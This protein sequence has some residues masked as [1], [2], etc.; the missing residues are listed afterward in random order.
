MIKAAYCRYGL[1][2]KEPAVTSRETMRVKDTY[3]IK[4]WDDRDS[5]TFGIGECALF[6]GLSCDD[7]PDYEEVLLDVCKRISDYLENPAV[8]LSEFPSIR[9]GV[10]TA[11][12]DFRNGGMRRIFPGKWADGQKALT[13]NGLVWMGDKHQMK[14][15]VKLKIKEGFRCVK[16][17]I[18]GISF[19]DEIAM[20]AGVRAAFPPEDLEIRVDANGA[21]APECAMERLDR[22][23]RFAIHSIEQPV[24]PR[25][26]KVMSELCRNSPIPIALDEELIGINRQKSKEEMLST[27]MPTYIILKPALCGGFSGSS[28]W[29]EAANNI[30]I[31]WWATSALE[32]NI[33]LNAISQWADSLDVTMPQG[34]GTGALYLNNIPSP[35]TLTGQYLSY[36]T[37][38]HW[39]LPQFEWIE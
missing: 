30:G 22:L 19:D 7:F 17:K 2:F 33:G 27:L 12:L 25:Q 1:V 5:R 16:F 11:L 28:E 35:V 34:L 31:G 13:I 4:I 9:F 39:T 20:I 18:G 23:S 21:F 36:N 3:F 15:R 32:S 6:R 8:S 26:W 29:I 24:K 14:Q 10:E 37:N 38:V